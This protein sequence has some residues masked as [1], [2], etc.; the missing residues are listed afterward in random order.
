MG[1]FHVKNAQKKKV[2]QNLTSIDSKEKIKP[3]VLTTEELAAISIALYK[4]SI[5]LHD[6]EHTILTINRAAKV[7]S[8]WSSKIHTLT[9]TPN[10]K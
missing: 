2:K 7:Y 8:P 5:S 9:Q 10:K 1:D 6:E 4:Y 3:S